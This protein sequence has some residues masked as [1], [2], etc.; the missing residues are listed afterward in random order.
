[1]SLP[2]TESSFVIHTTKSIQGFEHPEWPAVR[3]AL[4]VLNAAEGYL[5][6]RCFI[7]SDGGS[8]NCL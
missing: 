2:T 7:Y 4:E 6:V 1:M 3:V 5:W 8:L